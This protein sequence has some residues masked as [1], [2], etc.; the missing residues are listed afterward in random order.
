MYINKGNFKDS[1]LPHPPGDF[2]H[3]KDLQRFH[4]SIFAEFFTYSVFLWKGSDIAT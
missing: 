1:V 4:V 2:P 3:R